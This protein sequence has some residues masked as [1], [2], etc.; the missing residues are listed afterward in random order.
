MKVS[1]S[2]IVIA[3]LVIVVLAAFAFATV[4]WFEIVETKTW[5][6]AKGEAATNPYY[7]VEK[8]LPE[9]GAKLEIVQD[10]A[11]WQTLLASDPA[12]TRGVLILG[13]RRLA[14]MSAPRVAALRDWVTAGGHLIVEAEQS[15]LDDPV[16]AAFGV[17]R[18]RLQWIR[19]KWVAK[20]RRGDA[21]APADTVDEESSF[22]DELQNPHRL[23]D[24]DTEGGKA[25]EQKKAG[26]KAK[27]NV[28]A[29]AFPLV[30]AGLPGGHAFVLDFRPYQNLLLSDARAT[31]W[32]I[33]DDLG[34]R[35][36]QLRQGVGRGQVTVLSNF[37][38]MALRRLAKHDHGEFLW[39]LLAA[40]TD[41]VVDPAVKPT[42]WLAVRDP[43]GGLWNWLRTHAWMLVA[44]LAILLVAWIAR[45]VP[46]FGPLLPA[47]PLSR[48]SLALHVVAMGR[49][50]GKKHAY[51]PLA[52]VVRER[53]LAR[54]KRDNPALARLGMQDIA[55]A[56]EKQ[57]GL[58]AARIQRAMV[59]APRDRRSFVE[60]IQTLRSLEQHLRTASIRSR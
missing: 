32:R 7:L 58:G 18:V 59:S 23:P 44:A 26:Q 35:A 41:G 51:V 4:N 25:S 54:M 38:F 15:D 48:L 33:D 16:L 30:T 9:M 34:L 24:E 60:T 12:A 46:R 37:D 1:R 22:F 20:P 5:V 14:R 49:F 42:V 52:A 55:T 53:F 50:L 36:V 3:T 27:E 28:F 45:I 8:T 13:D 2:N 56:L 29:R 31:A 11:R 39:H 19:G 40:N 47:M 6:G 17:G 43:A 10:T 21:G 57:S